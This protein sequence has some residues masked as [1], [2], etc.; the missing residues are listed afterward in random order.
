MVADA[1]DD[2]A[3]QADGA[4]GTHAHTHAPEAHTHAPEAHTHAHAPS[5]SGPGG[6]RVLRHSWIACAGLN[7]A[8]EHFPCQYQLFYR[9][10]ARGS[11][12]YNPAFKVR[13]S[14]CVACALACVCVY[15]CACVC[16]VC[17]C[18]RA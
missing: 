17:L 18:M 5:A 2:L 14:A 8:Y 9:G 13:V 15:L 7:P 4:A 3:D 11:M 6:R 1:A 16:V 10:R 12:W